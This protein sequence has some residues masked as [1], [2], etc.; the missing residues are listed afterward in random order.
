[1]LASADS[2]HFVLDTDFWLLAA[3]EIIPFYKLNHAPDRT[4]TGL[5]PAFMRTVLLR[6]APLPAPLL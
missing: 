6:F 5:Q 3:Q 4:R 1:M 2:S